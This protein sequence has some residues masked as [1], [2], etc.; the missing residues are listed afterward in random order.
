MSDEIEF[1]E[2][3]PWLVAIITIIGIG[4]RV[5]LLATKGMWVDETVNV[6]LA[7]HSGPALL[8]WLSNIDQQP[9]MYYSLLHGWIAANGTTPYYARLFSVLFSAG[10]IPI[11]YLIGKR[12]AGPG[13]GLVAAALLAVSPFHIYYAQETSQYTLLLFNASVAMYALICLLMDA[14]C[15]API[16]SQFRDYFRAWRCPAPV[17]AGDTADFSYEHRSR[18]KTLWRTWVSRHQWLPVQS[19]ETDLAWVVFIVFSALTLLT[20]NSAVLFFAAANLFVFSLMLVQKVRRSKEQ[21][22]FWPPS[23]LNWLIAQ[24]VILALSFQWILSFIKKTGSADLTNSS[25]QP[26]WN[27]VLEVIKSFL[28]PSSAIPVHIAVWIWVLYAAVLCLGAVYYRRK[29]SYFLLLASLIVLPFAIELLVSIWRPVFSGQTLIWTTIPLFVLLASGVAQ[30]RY[31]LPVIAVVGLF[32]TLNLFAASDYYKFF[33]KEDWN[34]AAREVAGYA[35]K[36]DLVLFNSNVGEIPFDYYFEPY[37]S[38]YSIQ[39]EKQ[40]VPQDL[41]TTGIMAPEMTSG[42]IPALNSLLTGHDR[43]W[44]VISND[45]STD[46]QGLVPQTLASRL[47]LL[48]QNDFSGGQIQFYAR[49]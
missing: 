43:V 5:I 37:E 35:E 13:T 18:I 40:G 9:P 47:Q 1:D 33:Q 46:P 38:H 4:L 17:D 39:V 45:A 28:N 10:T 14:R 24:A 7:G 27:A 19:V 42:D 26:T 29:F 16:G 2:A 31:R 23:L 44:L 30:L 20:H 22:A 11:I 36:G 3:V 12:L 8:Q 41:L 32:C 6:W 48:H 21:S 49:Q 15:S 25:A 34:S